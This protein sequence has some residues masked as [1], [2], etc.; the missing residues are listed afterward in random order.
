VYL[1]LKPAP[2]DAAYAALFRRFLSGGFLLP[3]SSALPA[4]LPG[5]MSPGEEAALAQ[6]FRVSV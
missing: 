5:E 6:L 1:C 2:E 3:P 4:I